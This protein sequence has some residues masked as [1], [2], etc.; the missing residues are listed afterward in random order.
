MHKKNFSLT[1]GECLNDEDYQIL[2]FDV[3][4]DPNDN[5]SIQILLPPEEDIDAVLGTDKW[6]VRQAESEALGL[7]AATQIDFVAPKAGPIVDTTS[8]GGGCG[9]SKL[10]W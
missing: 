9:D 6:L 10:E 7:N 2:L 3:R 5:E 1:G 4:E 8:C